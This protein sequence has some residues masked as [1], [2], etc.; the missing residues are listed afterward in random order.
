MILDALA[1]LSLLA[2]V[3]FFVAGMLGVTRFP[4]AFCRLHAVTKSDNLGLGFV[5]LGLALAGGSLLSMAKLIL[6]W[7][8]A[9]GSSSAACF[10]V[11]RQVMIEENRA[12]RPPDDTAETSS[13]T[14]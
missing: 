3:I 2:A 4:D 14:I 11:A 5:V 8:L 9:V 1:V 10:L 13:S 12:N 6:I 7:M